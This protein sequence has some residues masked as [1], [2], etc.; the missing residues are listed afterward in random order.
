MLRGRWRK[1]GNCSP[2]RKTL[3]MTALR[4]LSVGGTPAGRFLEKQEQQPGSWALS[5]F[6]DMNQKR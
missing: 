1:S 6:L 3:R 2:E 5:A 4:S